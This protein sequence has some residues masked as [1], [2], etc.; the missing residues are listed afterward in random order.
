MRARAEEGGVEGLLLLAPGNVTYASGF[1]FSVNER[2]VGLYLPVEGDAVLL[3]PRLEAENA[4]DLDMGVEVYEEYPGETPLELWMMQRA[5]A[6]RLAVDALDARLLDDARAS[7]DRLDLV[8]HALPERAVK[9]PEEVTL[10]KVAA[11]FAD[12]FLERLMGSAA[13]IIA[14]GGTERD[15]LSDGISYARDALH[16]AHEAA[17]AGTKMGITATVHSGPRAA[18]P[19]GAVQ[20]RR[21]RPGETLIA[22]IG[23]SLGGYHA[24]SGVT[25]CIG[26]MS[27]EQRSVLTVMSEASAATIVALEARRPCDEV[28]AAALDVLRDAGHAKSLRHRIGHGMGTEGHEAPWLAPGDHTLTTPGMVFSCEPGIYRPG[29]DGYRT[30]DTLILTEAGVEVASRFQTEHPIDERVIPT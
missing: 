18:L 28:N 26:G 6:R 5:G 16:A 30:I 19:H 9:H 1:F 2:P 24:E 25:F 3:V 12:L 14:A 15:L 4:A 29:R 21:P 22:G 17:F 10:T 8:D 11:G 7:L 27:P 23:A 13:G 20:A